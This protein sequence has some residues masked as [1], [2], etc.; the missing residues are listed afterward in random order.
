MTNDENWKPCPPGTISDVAIELKNLDSTQTFKR[1]A[2]LTFVAVAGAGLAY[3]FVP[4][5]RR[6]DGIACEEIPGLARD[7]ILGQLPPQQLAK[8][9]VHLERCPPCADHVQAV[10]ESGTV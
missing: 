10:R 9:H 3:S 4:G 1:R 7:Y 2:V 8:M 5:R 6:H